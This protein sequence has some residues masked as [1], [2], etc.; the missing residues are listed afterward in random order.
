MK[1]QA[2]E[3][4]IAAA[5][6]KATIGGGGVALYGGLTAN[7]LAAFVGAAVAVLGL[8]VQIYFKRKDDKRKDEL[9]RWRLSGARFPDDEDES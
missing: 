8:L 2:I 5:A 1:D 7:E 9:Q 3:A 6:Q 4:T